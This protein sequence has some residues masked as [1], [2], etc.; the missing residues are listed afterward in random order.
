MTSSIVGNPITQLQTN[1]REG[2]SSNPYL[3]FKFSIRSEMTRK[4]DERRIRHFLTLLNLIWKIKTMSKNAV[5]PMCIKGAARQ[6]G[7]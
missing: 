1:V 5:M 7:P 2:T 6:N 4:Y 3:M